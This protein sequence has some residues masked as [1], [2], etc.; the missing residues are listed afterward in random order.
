MRATELILASG[1]ILVLNGCAHQTPRVGEVQGTTFTE[2]VPKADR[3]L[4]VSDRASHLRAES[5]PL[6]AAE[7]R[8]EYYVTWRGAGVSVVKF[9]YRQINA[10]DK[11]AALSMSPGRQHSNVFTIAGEDFLK[12][13]VVSA[14]RVSL[15]DGDRLLAERRS[16]L[17]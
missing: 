10:P 11:V 14:W 3:N 7:Q 17:W 1:I 15:W 16:T 12:G 4:F 6:P 13:G 8:E 9:E 5:V 2:T